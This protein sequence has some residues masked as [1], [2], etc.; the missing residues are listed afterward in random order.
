M[1]REVTVP[2]GRSGLDVVWPALR[3]ALRD[4]GAPVG[5]VPPDDGSRHSQRLRAAMAFDRN[6][7]ELDAI[8]AVVATSGSTGQPRGVML[9]ASALNALTEG[10]DYNWIV[11]LPLTSIGGLNV[12]IRAHHHDRRPAVLT[13]IG[14]AAAFSPDE[15]A[16]CIRESE[17]PAVSLVPTQLLRCLG[18]ADAIAALRDCALLLIGGA[19]LPEP[20]RQQC[21]ELAIPITTAY[22]ATET[23]GGCVWNGYPLPGV[24][25]TLG[26]DGRVIV[27]GPMLAKGYRADPSA[28]T[29]VFTADGF[30]TDDLGH[31]D[32]KGML[33]IMGRA[34]DVVVIRGVNVSLGAVED[35][36]DAFPGVNEC[37]VTVAYQSDDEPELIAWIVGN[38][39]EVDAIRDAVIGALGTPAA[40]RQYRVVTELPHLPNG[41]LDRQALGHHGNPS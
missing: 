4:G 33:T 41:K 26:S 27:N 38:P 2:P 1:L 39:P 37:A 5:F 17:A 8:S 25:V 28:T 6:D 40:P 14:G 10:P 36:I 16:Q 3:D 34:D 21:R 11:A 24:T 15:L 30:R 13:S 32:A 29:Q 9:T 20:L 35:T 19:R 31:I 22:G 18:N 12:V 23:A 7:D